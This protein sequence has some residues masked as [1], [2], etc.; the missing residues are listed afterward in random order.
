MNTSHKK[1]VLLLILDGWGHRTATDSNAIHH[2]NT[3]TWDRLWQQAPHA[4]LSCSGTDVGLPAG[5]M[6]NSEVGHTILGSGR[7]V[8]QS[9]T[10][11]DRAIENGEFA[12]N[13]AYLH[14][15]DHAVTTDNAVHI[16]G[17]A[18]PGGIHSHQHHIEAM[19]EL[20]AS[21]GAKK[22]YLHAFLDGRDTPPR[23]AQATLE[24]L[25]DQFDRLGCGRIASII[26]RYY[27]MDRDQRWQRTQAAYD[28]LT[29]SVADYQS[30]SAIAGLLA[31]YQRDE[32]DEFVSATVIRCNDQP[33]ATI[34]DH[35][36]VI[37]MNF[38]ADR[39]R[40]LSHAFVDQSFDGFTRACLP[41]LAHF[42]TTTR[43]DD[44]LD[45]S[46]AFPPE[47]IEHDVGEVM[48]AHDKTQLRIAET[49]K[50][51]H[52]TFFSVVAARSRISANSESSCHHRKS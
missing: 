21:R 41:Q 18:S 8:Y 36:S 24:A 40:Q 49:E 38:R 29:A 14:A 23:S 30:D 35:D 27:A 26:G 12:D 48:E 44:T 1:P 46:C 28:L 50:Y 2:A 22:V 15:I 39:A 52:V 32:N 51:A 19:I 4:L 47:P 17:L 7:V 45:A 25:T 33:A 6:G 16:L 9:L 20:A 31:A 10:R 43:Y 11:V 34:K 42:V 13:P 37:V 3:P 5:Q